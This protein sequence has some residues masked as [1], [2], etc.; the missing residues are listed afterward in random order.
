MRGEK[1]R[2]DEKLSEVLRIKNGKKILKKLIKK[3]V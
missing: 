3:F 1:E 2:R